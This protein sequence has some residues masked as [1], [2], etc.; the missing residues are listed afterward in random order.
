MSSGLANLLLGR[1]PSYTRK[2]RHLQLLLRHSNP[3]KLVNVVRSEIS[4]MRGEIV[5][6][7]LPYIYIIDT[8]NVCNLRCPLCPTGYRGLERP[9]AMMTL[10]HFESIIEKIRPYAVEVILH[11]WGEPFLN[12]DIL[13]MI[14][15]ARGNG[16]GTTLSSN[17]NLVNRG[18][19]FLEEVVESGLEHLTVSID[20]TTQEVYEK[21]RKGGKLEEVLGNLRYLMEHRRRIGSAHPIIE[22][23]FLVMK[24]NEHQ[25]P[26]ARRM[27]EEIGVDRTRFTG[28]GLPFKELTNAG[29]AKEWLSEL[30]QYR[31]YAPESFQE[32]GYLY[33]ERCFYLYRAMTVN[34][35]GAVSPC[36]VVYEQSADFGNLI[37]DGLSEVWNN[38]QY[39]SSRALFSRKPGASGEETICHRCPLFRYEKKPAGALTNI[40]TDTGARPN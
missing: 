40:L 7:S 30:P 22:W 1:L 27:A 39:R 8:G 15:H 9:Q 36:C 18:E 35:G 25:I 10:A 13:P 33:D 3:R 26:D 17:L 21:Y 28:A 31:G 32:R 29:M 37:H 23:Q 6:G 38:Q 34:P 2:S 4:R 11:N 5:L 12:P 24:H 16:I 14:R 20:G 19:R